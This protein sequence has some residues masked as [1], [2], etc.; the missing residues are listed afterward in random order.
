MSLHQVAEISVP[1]AL[2]VYQT[3]LG[4]AALRPL[5]PESLPIGLSSDGT[6]RIDRTA[7]RA[8]ATRLSDRKQIWRRRADY[9]VYAHDQLL[10]LSEGKVAYFSAQLRPTRQI[11][12]P[13]SSV[14]WC[15][16]DDSQKQVVGFKRIKGS[17]YEWSVY[18]Y[19]LRSRLVQQ[20]PIA[21]DIGHSLDFQMTSTDG[22]AVFSDTYRCYVIRDGRVVVPSWS[23]P[24]RSEG[25]FDYATVD[26]LAMNSDIFVLQ[27]KNL[28]SDYRI[29][30]ASDGEVLL[31]T[32]AKLSGFVK[33]SGSGIFVFQANPNSVKVFEL[34]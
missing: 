13:K 8:T 2:Q 10:C 29:V 12:L 5:S 34:R 15:F 7:E 24:N 4:Y 6:W 1:A 11:A 14:L 25:S 20:L 27:V 19:D 17:P 31:S 3:K 9:T 26:L 18:F 16:L 28:G 22:L 21:Y 23:A 32:Q 33:Q 30:K